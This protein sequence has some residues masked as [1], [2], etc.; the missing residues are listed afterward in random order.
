MRKGPSDSSGHF[1]RN[2]GL[3]DKL[4][5]KHLHAEPARKIRKLDS[6]MIFTVVAAVA[7][8]WLLETNH[9]TSVWQQNYNPVGHWLLS[10]LVASFR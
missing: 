6:R 10:A 7:A 9:I 3:T 2:C 1:R 5:F 8:A 4:F